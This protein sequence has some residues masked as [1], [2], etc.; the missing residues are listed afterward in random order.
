MYAC[1]VKVLLDTYVACTVVGEVDSASGVDTAAANDHRVS[2]KTCVDCIVRAS[3]IH[4]VTFGIPICKLDTVPLM[5]ETAEVA[6]I[7]SGGCEL[8]STEVIES[9]IV[10]SGDLTVINSPTSG[11]VR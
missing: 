10:S 8:E 11:H 1:T 3:N 6:C 5:C 9:V 7:V 4:E 2:S